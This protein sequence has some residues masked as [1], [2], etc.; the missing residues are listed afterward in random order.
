MTT[1]KENLIKNINY[2]SISII[3]LL[4]I[5]VFLG[6]GV[7]NLS[8]IILDILFIYEIY[9]KK[10]FKYFHNKVF[11]LINFLLVYSIIKLKF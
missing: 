8:I 11:L 7:L 6:S 10:N 4:P 9:L 1:I 3:F 5:I 2:I